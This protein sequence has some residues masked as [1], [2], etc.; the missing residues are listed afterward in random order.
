MYKS[1]RPGKVWYD[2]QGKMIQA[3]GGSIIF[4]ENKFWWY[5]ENKENITGKATGERCP[6]WHHGVKLYSSNDL[7]NWKDEGFCVVESSEEKNP[8]YPKNIMDRPHVLFNE[9]TGNY[10]LWAKTSCGGDFFSCSFSI[11]VGKTLKN[12]QFVKEVLPAPHHA[13][14]FDLFIYKGRG[15]IVY[16]NPH[17]ELVVRE[18]T[19]DYM[20]VTDVYSTHFQAKCPPFVREA[21]AVFEY[22]EKLYMLTSGT[23]GYYPNATE[24]A[25]ITDIHGE[26]KNFGNACMGDKNNNSFH[27]QFSSVFKHPTEKDVYIAL[28]DR[29]LMDLPVDLPDMNE[30]FYKIFNG[31]PLDVDF[32]ALTDENTSVAAYVWLKICFDG[33]DKPY[34]RWER[35]W[36]I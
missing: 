20:D 1:V 34:I 23:T 14:D 28:G 36:D 19:E 8:F 9:K 25:D 33:E 12:M 15:Y 35:E 13:G 30:V 7:Y 10:V 11:C 32:N 22:K 5:G 24:I 16:E 27:S 3:H 26:W 6:Y 29:W 31:E 2:T 4:A 21:P 17:S 18:L